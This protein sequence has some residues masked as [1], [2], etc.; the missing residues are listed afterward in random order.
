[1]QPAEIIFCKEGEPK[2]APLLVT[3]VSISHFTFHGTI[4]EILNV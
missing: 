1:M 4:R 2:K 3:A